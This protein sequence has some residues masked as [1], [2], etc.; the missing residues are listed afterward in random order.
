MIEYAKGV[1]AETHG[2]TMDAAFD[3]LVVLSRDQQRPLTVVA[4]EVV[5]RASARH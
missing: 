1:L 4:T 5:D 2:L 3:R